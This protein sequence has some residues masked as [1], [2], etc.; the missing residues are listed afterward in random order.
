MINRIIQNKFVAA[1]TFMY[2]ALGF[3]SFGNYLYHLL[4]TR[5][6]PRDALGELEGVIAFFYI[7]S[8][9]LLTLS[10]VVV[11]FVSQYK[12]SGRSEEIG[13]FYHYVQRKILYLSVLGALG[14]LLISPFIVSLLHLSSYVMV[15]LL[16]LSLAL[17]FFVTFGRSFLQGLSNF[18]GYAASITVESFVKVAAAVALVFL[19]FQTAGAFAAVLIGSVVGLAV[20]LLY[21][22]QYHTSTKQVIKKKELFS[23]TFPV[24]ITTLAISSLYST[25]VIL[26]RHFFPGGLSGDYAV[27]SILGKV[28][29]FA[30]SPVA[31]VLFPFVSEMHAK[32]EKHSQYLLLSIVLTVIGAS[33]ITAVYFLFPSLIIYLLPGDKYA[34]I[35]PLLGYMGIYLGLYTVCALIANYY[36]S[37][38]KTM[39][40]YIV[41][42]AAFFQIAGI[43]FFHSSL[44]Q[45]IY[46]SIIVTF[47]LLIALLLYYPYAKGRTAL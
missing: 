7:L 5:M 20:L 24:F 12:G 46:V 15:V 8:V 13:A 22:K 33:A 39:Q 21:T 34:H 14:M 4:M 35:A 18:F 38:H 2:F 45:V 11:K 36:L 43:I 19:G 47:L 17:S 27:L 29:F 44:I 26:V 10:L 31:T 16:A 32:G 25:D 37:I 42:L 23:F 6:L 41:M 3:G 1:A 28:I 30:L 40:S 9:P